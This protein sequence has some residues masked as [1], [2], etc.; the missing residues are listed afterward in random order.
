MTPAC[1]RARMPRA[2][3][4][5]LIERPRSVRERRG[6]GRRSHSR[7]APQPC[8]MRITP[9]SA[10]ASPGTDYVDR[11]VRVSPQPASHSCNF[12]QHLGEALTEGEHFREAIIQRDGRDPDDVGFAPI[13]DDIQLGQP[14]E[15]APAARTAAEY[16]DR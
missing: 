11:L 2:A 12:L 8:R 4:A 15:H 7:M 16:A 3:N 14:V 13:A 1:S 5:R 9:S 6:S 10:P